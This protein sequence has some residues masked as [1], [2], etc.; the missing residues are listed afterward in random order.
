MKVFTWRKLYT[1]SVAISEDT[2]K[3]HHA[4]DEK[5]S[6]TLYPYVWSKYGGW[7]NACDE[8]TVDQLRRKIKNG[9]AKLA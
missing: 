8:L 9:T 2:G 1:Y 3:V 6:K 4:T 5:A 7:D